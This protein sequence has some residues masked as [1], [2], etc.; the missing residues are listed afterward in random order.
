G[1]AARGGERLRAGESVRRAAG[2]PDEP[3]RHHRVASAAVEAGRAVAHRDPAHAQARYGQQRR[4][5]RRHPGRGGRPARSRAAVQH[6]AV[7][8]PS[9]GSA[10]ECCGPSALA[11]RAGG[12]TPMTAATSLPAAPSTPSASTEEKTAFLWSL[13]TAP[14]AWRRSSARVIRLRTSRA[15]REGGVARREDSVGVVAFTGR[16]EGGPCGAV[17]GAPLL[18]R[19]GY[20]ADRVLVTP[21]GLGAQVEGTVGLHH[22]LRVLG[23]VR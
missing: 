12:R 2:R 10:A 4:R 9:P 1:A 8:A 18:R 3:V 16:L 11:A 7:S 17:V 5:R 14:L 23:S 15:R 22:V 6:R 19:G 13:I 21:D 20:G